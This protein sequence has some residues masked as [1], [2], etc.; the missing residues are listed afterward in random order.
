MLLVYFRI[1]MAVR[2]AKGHIP[3]LM[4][5]VLRA[6]AKDHILTDAVFQASVLIR[7]QWH[8]LKGLFDVHSQGGQIERHLWIGCL[9]PGA[10]VLA[11][12]AVTDA[13]RA[14]T[15]VI[16]SCFFNI[17]FHSSPHTRSHFSPFG[18]RRK[19]PGIRSSSS[20]VS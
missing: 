3:D 6:A 9:H 19:L 1:G 2:A 15:T 11:V 18:I 20:P 8:R 10:V 4:G 5:E 13:L 7:L 16:G 14:K 12:V 17:C